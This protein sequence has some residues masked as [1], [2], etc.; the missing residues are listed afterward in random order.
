MCE[1]LKRLSVDI[2]PG[3]TSDIILTLQQ[4]GIFTV[5]ELIAQKVEELAVTTHISCK[6][7]PNLANH[8]M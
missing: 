6:V 1:Q 2:C 3:L 5:S 7:C 4:N 8:L